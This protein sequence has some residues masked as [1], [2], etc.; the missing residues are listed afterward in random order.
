[1]AKI[2][3]FGDSIIWGA[4]DTEGGWAT[5]LKKY[6]DEN[7]KEDFNYQVYNLGVSGDTTEDLLDRFEFETKQRINEEEE[8]IFIFG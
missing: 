1:M 2:L 8:T 5:R 3:I 6:F 4:F 7:R